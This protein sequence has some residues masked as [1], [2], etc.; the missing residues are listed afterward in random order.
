MSLSKPVRI[1][2]LIP[3]LGGGGA[4]HVIETLARNLSP[5][6]YD[7]H[8]AV[9]TSSHNNSTRLAPHIA[10]HELNASRVRNSASKLLRL[11]WRIRPRIILSGM[12]HLNLLVLILRPLVPARTHILVR[13]NGA[14]SAT[15]TSFSQNPLSRV[16]YSAAYRH[17]DRVICQ[18]ETMA[19][20]MQRELRVPRRN[21]VVLPNPTDLHRIRELSPSGRHDSAEPV[22]SSSRLAVSSL[23]RASTSSS[24]LLPPCPRLTSRPNSLSPATASR[25][26]FWSNRY[27]PSG[28]I[29]V[30]TL[31]DIRRIL[32]STLATHHSMCSHP[33]PKGYLTRCLKPQPPAFR[34]WPRQHLR[35]LRRCLK[36][37]KAC[38]WLKT[39]RLT[40]S[41][42]LWKTP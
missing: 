38:G 41:E 24:M 18:T 32:S 15:L 36:T 34:L 3:H 1:L 42:S 33:A 22:S 25:D 28:F 6:K 19:Q 17:A 29:I 5:G 13:Q 14:L 12:A 27:K 40:H 39:S 37:A 21:L 11:I 2:L 20:E 10:L 4:E 9:I 7:I 35:D 23:R 16:V 31:P 8:V 26:H 30:S